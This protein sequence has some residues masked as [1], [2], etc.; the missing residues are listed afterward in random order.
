M[1]TICQINKEI[2]FVA[3]VCAY[4]CTKLDAD[5]GRLVQ[6]TINIAFFAMKT[7]E[8]V[9]PI[10]RRTSLCDVI[11]DIAALAYIMY[12]NLLY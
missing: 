9:L 6:F 7:V 5:D 10:C 1:Y 8:I 4:C 2:Y 11:F 12:L 3:D